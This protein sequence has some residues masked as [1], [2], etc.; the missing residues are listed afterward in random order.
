MTSL[1]IASYGITELGRTA[2]L[3]QQTREIICAHCG[4]G[5][6][7]KNRG[8]W[9]ISPTF[10]PSLE[11]SAEGIFQKTWSCDFCKNVTIEMIIAG[12]AV[13]GGAARPVSEIIQLWPRRAVRELPE[14]VPEPIRDR[15]REG[16]LCE[17]VAAYRG[18]AA[19]YRA[20]V[21][22]LCQDQG[23]TK[24]KLYDKIEELREH[25]LD[26][27]LIDA[28]HETRMLGNDSVHD[29][30]IYSPGEVADVAELIGE[31]AESLYVAPTRKAAMREAR[32]QR[33]EAF[34]NTTASTDS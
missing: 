10:E 16:S 25:R 34:K 2:N 31:V 26:D 12:V 15:F 13:G 4:Y 19:M 21:E 32:R 1:L 7:Q 23:A 14:E 22:E 20:A 6:T 24:Y 30:M 5:T 18:A 11:K 8:V 29:G 33:R 17:G 28:L 9:R 27:D 3:L